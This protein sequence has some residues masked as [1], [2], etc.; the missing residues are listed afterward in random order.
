MLAGVRPTCRRRNDANTAEEGRRVRILV[1]GGAGFI[2]SHLVE[3]LLLDGHDVRVLDNFTSGRR[4]NLS[5]VV[6]D[7]DLVE[8]DI[9][10]YER[11]SAAVRGRDVVLHQAA[12]PSVARSI[13]DP[14]TSNAANVV[15]TLNVLLAARDAGVRRV[16]FASSSSIYGEAGAFPKAESLTPAPISPYAVSKLTGEHYCSA[17]FH[18]Y[19]L[20]TVVLRYFNVFGPR[21]HAGSD[22]AA[23]IPRFVLALTEGRAPTVYGDGEQTRDFTYVDNVVDANVLAMTANEAVG[24][25]FNVGGGQATSVNKL[26][27]ELAS[28]LGHSVDARYVEPRPGDIRH[29]RADISLAWSTLGYEPRIGLA[30]GL[31]RMVRWHERLAG[32][33]SMV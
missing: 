15:G 8:G 1:T 25:V 24:R 21:Q 10:S 28:A 33:P 30:E 26:L 6:P 4:E 5:D 7:I 32:D 19:K 11:V 20:E 2:G 3:R 27:A 9:Q 14:L 13:E 29:S 12:K 16:V 17:C 31:R 22:Y 18:V 23:A